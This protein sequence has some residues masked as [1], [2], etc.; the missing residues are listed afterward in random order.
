MGNPQDVIQLFRPPVGNGPV[1]PNGWRIT[2]PYAN[3]YALKPGIYAYHTGADLMLQHGSSAKQPIYA[4]ADGLVTFA[5]RVPNSTWGYLLVV[6]HTNPDGGHFYSRYGHDNDF[7][8]AEGD[9][10][11]M[12]QMIAHVGNAFGAFAYHLHFDLSLTDTLLTHP[13]DWPGLD[14][15]RVYQTYVDP[16]AYLKG[17]KMA[18]PADQ[19]KAY[20]AQMKLLADGLIA[21]ADLIPPPVSSAPPTP[22]APLA[23]VTKTNETHVRQ[24]PSTTSALVATLTANTALNVVDANTEANGY[25]WYKIVDG[26]YTGAFIAQQVVTPKV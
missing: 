21:Q 15:E 24:L 2:N 4:I 25:T 3:Y 1:P 18:T 20:A 17:Q 8:I 19:I 6:Q 13:T 16:I 5:R 23:V 22:P 14:L 10:V 26:P 7:L 12:G 9:H 11:F